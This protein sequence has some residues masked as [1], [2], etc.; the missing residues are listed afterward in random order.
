MG[1]V[2][3]ERLERV[4]DGEVHLAAMDLV[5]PAGRVTTVFGPTRAGKTSLLRVIAGLAPPTGGAVR[6]AGSVA[7]VYQEFVNYPSLTVYENIASPLRVA[8]TPRAEID[9]RVLRIATQL[10]LQSRLDR[11]PATLSGGEQQRVALGRAL[12]KDADVVLLDEPLANLDFKLREELRGELRRLFADGRRTVLYATTDAAEALS[13][14]GDVAVL[15]QGRLLAHAPVRDVFDRPDDRRVAELFGDPP[16][17]LLAATPSADGGPPALTLPTG[18]RIAAP[19]AGAAT[20]AG[21]TIG[22]RPH[23]L[24][25][26]ARGPDAIPLDVAVDDVELH[27]DSTRVRLRHGPLELLLLAPGSRVDEA[28]AATAVY[29][30]PR[31]ALVF[32]AGGR[33]LDPPEG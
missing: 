5:I 16:M 8:R 11:R 9:R 19:A 30:D 32:D 4:V 28:R 27:G 3:L 13:F 23:H 31:R 17:N 7:M 18:V 6:V 12:A 24:A 25:L 15:D 26:T 1:D 14:A 22:I 10:G 20:T 21:A 33:R 29:V 2:H